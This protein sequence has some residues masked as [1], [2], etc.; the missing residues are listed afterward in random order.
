LT[1]ATFSGLDGRHA[2]FL[3]EIV[4]LNVIT[5]AAFA[6]PARKHGLLA[7]GAMEAIN[8]WSFQRYDEALLD[9]GEPIEIA[10][11]LVRITEQAAR[12]TDVL[13]APPVEFYGI[14]ETID[15]QRL[16]MVL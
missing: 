15:L 16:I 3:G 6:D 7:A 8:E 5:Q 14:R 9:D 2:S 12:K 1:N 13:S 10:R 11:H 4:S